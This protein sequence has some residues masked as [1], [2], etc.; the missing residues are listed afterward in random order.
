MLNAT[1]KLSCEVCGFDFKARYGDLGEGYAECHHT[2]PVS[3]LKKQQKTK[4]SDLS[5]LCANC[6]RMIHRSRPMLSIEQ[7]KEQLLIVQ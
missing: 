7:L 6:H 1:G 3:Q 4:L 5:I 2:I